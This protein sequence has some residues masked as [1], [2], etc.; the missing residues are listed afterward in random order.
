MECAD[1]RSNACLERITS[2][3][4]NNP[5]TESLNLIF[6]NA[7]PS[8]E[9]NGL[10]KWLMKHILFLKAAEQRAVIDLALDKRFITLQKQKG[11]R[12]A[13]SKCQEERVRAEEQ[14]RAPT[15][16][17]RYLKLLDS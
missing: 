11:I 15:Q 7:Y 2:V 1:V 13:L 14:M 6:W 3:V 9:E 4:K 12:E 10:N 16:I 5:I 17:R 8:N